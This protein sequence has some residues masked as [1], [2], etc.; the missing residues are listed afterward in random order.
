MIVS[1]V[2]TI[3]ITIT[4]ATIITMTSSCFFDYYYPHDA[5]GNIANA[6][7]EC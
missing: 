3:C 1:F 6:C 4:I 5:A 7:L 2:V